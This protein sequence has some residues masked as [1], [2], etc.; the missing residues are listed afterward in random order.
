MRLRV[1]R[2]MLAVAGGAAVVALVAW[3]L[4]P[5]PVVVDLVPAVEGPLELTVRDEGE[6]RVRDRY[7]VTAPVPGY[8][9]RLSLQEGQAVEAGTEIAH[10]SV[11]PLD[12][13]A[14][15]QAAA[16]LEGARDTQRT[17]AA[18]VVQARAALAQAKRDAARAATLVGAGAAAREALEQAELSAALREKELEAADFRAQSAAHDVETARA[19]LLTED[20][21]GRPR[22][23]DMVIRSPAAGKVLRI[24]EESARVVAAG[25]PL[26]EIGDPLR[27]EIT[28]DLVST[29]AVK[30]RPGQS[31]VIE[32][33]GGEHP[34]RGRV[35]LVEPS[36][37][38][39]VSALGVE[40][41]RVNVVGD[42]L[43]PAEWLG[44]RYRV[45][46]RIVIWQADR[47]LKVPWSAIVREGN[48]WRV[49][50]ADGDRA[51][52]RDVTVGRQG[53]FEVQILDG[54]Q[55]GD[56]VVR[57][58]TDQIVDGARLRAR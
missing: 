55:A 36:G 30:V 54:L 29:D 56:L 33:W 2:G 41:Q 50:V 26:V 52:A 3:T 12:E 44:D 5:T 9:A 15:A 49:F 37:F 7:I 43:E 39:K 10:L 23:R 25:E 45:Q 19:A 32:G 20:G 6:T 47:V 38:T 16:T 31:M 28:S 27:L 13:R 58:P 18:M 53:E 24:P 11:L 21:E 17:A 57:H 51:R 42:L 22:A 14:R 34:L 46:V 48:G 4:R 35:R 1:S 40:E 8:L